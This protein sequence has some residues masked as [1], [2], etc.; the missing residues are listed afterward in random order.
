M[1]PRSL[2]RYPGRVYSMPQGTGIKFIEIGA[3]L[4]TWMA[5]ASYKVERSGSSMY[6]TPSILA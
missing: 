6:D 4:P 3:R 1:T 5:S 2:V